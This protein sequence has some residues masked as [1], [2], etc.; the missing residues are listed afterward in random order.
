MENVTIPQY[1]V[2]QY[3]RGRRNIPHGVIVAVKVS[4]GFRLGY[5]LCCKRDRFNKRMA[6]KIALGRTETNA[7]VTSW[8][9]AL[10]ESP[11]LQRDAIGDPIPHPVKKMLPSFLDR[12]KRYYKVNA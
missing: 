7:T 3:V 11:H 5:S 12:C 4:D 1:T 2:I 6:L 10:A 8:P 9:T